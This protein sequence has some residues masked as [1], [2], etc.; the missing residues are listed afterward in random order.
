MSILLS[1]L[2][3][4]WKAFHKCLSP[5]RSVTKIR[6]LTLQRNTLVHPRTPSLFCSF[7]FCSYMWLIVK[8]TRRKPH[9]LHSV[10]RHFHFAARKSQ[11]WVTFLTVS[12]LRRAA[13]MEKKRNKTLKP[14]VGGRA[15]VFVL[16]YFTVA[17]LQSF[18]TLCKKIF[19]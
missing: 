15:T 8:V 1:S 11:F 19:F 9:A 13:L 14:S 7:T 3:H 17:T 18:D 6:A 5:W 2:L 12:R 16:Y 4:Y 10:C